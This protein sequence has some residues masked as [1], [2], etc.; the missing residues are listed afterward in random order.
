MKNYSI[1]ALASIFM[2]F[3]FTTT[4]ATTSAATLSVTVKNVAN[5]KGVVV[6]SV[7]DKESFKADCTLIQTEK[8]V[9]G[10]VVVNFKDVA[11]GKYAVK[12]F[13]DENENK[14]MD[15]NFL[16][17]PKEAYGFSRDAR[18]H[19]GP[20]EFDAAMIEIKDGANEISLVLDY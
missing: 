4:S 2:A 12:V 13:H 8:A 1:P 16:G 5:T 19:R 6:V 10:P 17:I 11:P 20:P 9:V 15:R 14:K 7:C 18:G 3:A